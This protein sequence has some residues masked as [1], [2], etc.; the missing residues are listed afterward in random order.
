MPQAETY[1]D[2][3][4]VILPLSFYCVCITCL[5]FATLNMLAP[6]FFSVNGNIFLSANN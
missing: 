4:T 6:F 1:L 5:N 2:M 3:I